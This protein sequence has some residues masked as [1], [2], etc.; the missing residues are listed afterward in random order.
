MNRRKLIEMDEAEIQA[1]L[2][3]ERVAT[4]GTFG[5]R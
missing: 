3:E 4:V 5:P 1:F 2:G